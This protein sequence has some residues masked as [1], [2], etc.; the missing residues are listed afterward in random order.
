MHC[1]AT[2]YL[3]RFI[4]IALE[5]ENNIVVDDFRGQNK[6]NTV[7]R[8]VNANLQQYIQV[9]QRALSKQ[10]P[11]QKLRRKDFQFDEEMIPQE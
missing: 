7:L 9:R 5:C 2:H 6:N 10:G 4:G 1:C 8:N 11:H 3:D